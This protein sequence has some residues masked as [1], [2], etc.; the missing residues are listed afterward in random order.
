MKTDNST[1]LSSK[2]TINNYLRME[3]EG[4]RHGIA[5]MIRL[6]HRERY[7]NPVECSTAKHGFAS[8]ALAC[9]LVET[10]QSFREGLGDTKGKSRA[11]FRLFLTKESGFEKFVN[12][13]DSFFDDVR[14]GLLH[15]GETRRGWTVM[16]CGPL[17]D[18]GKKQLNATRF[19]K[20]VDKSL[21]SYCQEL[22]H[23]DWNSNQWK[24][25]RQKMAAIISNCE[26]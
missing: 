11:M 10:I 19:L 17:F 21:N 7:V 15:Q 8:M 5:E 13:A 14:C 24:K 6:R 23:A 16:R 18:L 2:H 4:D 20:A 9:L 26:K 22:E 25:C 3:K 12:I 1:E